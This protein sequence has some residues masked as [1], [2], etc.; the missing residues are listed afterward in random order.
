MLTYGYELTYEHE[1]WVRTKRIRL[2]IQGAQINFLLRVLSH[3]EKTLSRATSPSCQSQ[4][5]WFGNLIRM[6][7]GHL[8][9]EVF[10]PCP[11]KGDTGVE[12]EHAGGILY[13]IWPGNPLDP[14]RGSIK[15]C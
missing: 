15:C 13:L 8:P 1:L 2:Q 6:P 14:P 4:L 9:L 11:T 7:P 3:P 10:R 5:R 12:A